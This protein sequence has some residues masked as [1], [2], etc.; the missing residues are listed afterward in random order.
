MEGA[1]PADD[2]QAVVGLFD[3]FDG[4][5]A[6]FEDGRE[7]V[8][9]RGDLGGQQLRGDE[10]VVADDWIILVWEMFNGRMKG[11]TA[12]VVADALEF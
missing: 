12:D 11:H 3:D 9:W 2:Q 6:A 4:F 5:F 10:R 1:G 8:G 7:G